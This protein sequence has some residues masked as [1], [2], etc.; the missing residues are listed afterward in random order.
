MTLVFSFL[1]NNKMN[2]LNIDFIGC[3]TTEKGIYCKRGLKTITNVD[4]FLNN[5]KSSI[6]VSSS[7]IY[8]SYNCVPSVFVKFALKKRQYRL[9]NKE[10][11]TYKRLVK[12]YNTE[13]LV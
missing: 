1:L 3:I 4:T 9:N 2:L 12:A 10:T 8:V 11:S 6:R 5:Y 13:I 7:F